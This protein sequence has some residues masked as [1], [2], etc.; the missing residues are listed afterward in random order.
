[1]AIK[2]F[3]IKLQHLI[4]LKHLKFSL[5][6]TNHII[7]IE[8][9][10]NNIDEQAF[11]SS[12]F[13]GS[14]LFEDMGVILYGKPNITITDLVKADELYSYNQEQKDEMSQLLKELPTVLEIILSTQSFSIGNYKMK[15]HEGIWNKYEPKV[16]NK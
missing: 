10:E 4:L 13:G 9:H 5:T 1:M 11:I 6:D 3:E 2:K 14:N 16:L 8:K 7:S 12:P 15:L